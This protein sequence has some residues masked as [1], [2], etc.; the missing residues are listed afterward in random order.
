MPEF[1]LSIL[2]TISLGLAALVR[3]KGGSTCRFTY[4]TIYQ[5]FLSLCSIN[6]RI[7]F[8]EKKDQGKIF[9]ADPRRYHRRW[10][11]SSK[12]FLQVCCWLYIV[13]FNNFEVS[14]VLTFCRGWLIIRSDGV[15]FLQSIF[16]AEIIFLSASV[17]QLTNP[18]SSLLRCFSLAFIFCKQWACSQR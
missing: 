3:L 9:N 13:Y 10:W 14:L 12:I 2:I 7:F 1:C 17:S 6:F 16:L 5:V 11:G 18:E 4:H 8:L 15:M